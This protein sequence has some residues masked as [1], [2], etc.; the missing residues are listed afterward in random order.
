[1]ETGVSGADKAKNQEAHFYLVWKV[2]VE[3]VADGDHIHYQWYG[4]GSGLLQL[5]LLKREPNNCRASVCTHHGR[6]IVPVV[7]VQ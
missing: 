5:N 1:M 4:R 6:F 7:P 3:G 2:G